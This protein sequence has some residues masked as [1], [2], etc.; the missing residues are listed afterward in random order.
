M[1]RNNRAEIT[2]IELIPSRLYRQHKKNNDNVGAAR[3]NHV[4]GIEPKP[5][6][7]RLMHMVQ[8][9]L[10]AAQALMFWLMGTP[11][12]QKRDEGKRK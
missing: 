6:P 11:V 5:C 9:Q 8:E 2:S 10:L 4:A 1:H 7:V 3:T 12:C